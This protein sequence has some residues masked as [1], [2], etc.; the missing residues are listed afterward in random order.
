MIEAL[1]SAGLAGFKDRECP[2]QQ[3]AG[4][5][6]PARGDREQRDDAGGGVGE[7]HQEGCGPDP[8]ARQAASRPPTPSREN[9]VRP[10]GAVSCLTARW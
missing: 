7:Q 6:Q 3:E 4:T 5:A 1:S 9:A 10:P 2:G 8:V